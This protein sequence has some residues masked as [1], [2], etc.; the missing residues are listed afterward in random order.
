LI[1]HVDVQYDYTDW[2][3]DIGLV[4]AKLSQHIAKLCLK[5]EKVHVASLNNIPATN[6]FIHICV[7]NLKTHI[8]PRLLGVFSKILV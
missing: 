6:K 1:I 5:A 7:S 3:S 8:I 4:K 2:I